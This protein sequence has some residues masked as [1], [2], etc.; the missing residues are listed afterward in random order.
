MQHLFM[1]IEKQEWKVKWM[2][3]NSNVLVAKIGK[4]DKRCVTE[5]TIYNHVMYFCLNCNDWVKNKSAV[6]EPN[7]T[8][9]DERVNLRSNL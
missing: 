6:L 2:R 7:W 9:M 3:K 5:H 1:M 4:K 8:L